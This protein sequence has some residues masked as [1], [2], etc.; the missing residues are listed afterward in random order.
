MA[1]E[2]E[3]YAY[4]RERKRKIFLGCAIFLACCAIALI[5]ATIARGLYINLIVQI[6]CLLINLKLIYT[7]WRPR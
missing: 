7:Y 1:L 5:A 3:Q 4:K 6:I 2:P